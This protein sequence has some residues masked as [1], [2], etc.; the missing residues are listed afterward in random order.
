MNDFYLYVA[1]GG[2]LLALISTIINFVWLLSKE[3]H[4]VVANPDLAFS[5]PYRYSLIISLIIMF[6]GIMMGL[7]SWGCISKEVEIFILLLPILI[8]MA[9]DSKIYK[10]FSKKT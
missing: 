7:E 9:I 2:A 8:G 6:I 5:K 10:K 3:L 1:L 4:E